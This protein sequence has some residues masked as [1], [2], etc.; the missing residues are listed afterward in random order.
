MRESGFF[1]FEVNKSANKIQI[2]NAVEK[3]FGVNVVD[4]KVLNTKPKRKMLR[5]KRGYGV[6]SSY[7]KALVRL[8]KG[9]TISEIEV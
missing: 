3:I 1:T 9:Q 4:C 2:T 7:K 8:K 6:T 5:T